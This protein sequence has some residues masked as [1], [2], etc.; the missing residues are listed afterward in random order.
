MQKTINKIAH[1][2]RGVLDFSLIFNSFKTEYEATG[3]PIEV[4][5]RD[6]VKIYSGI[7][8]YT[9]LIH[10]YPAK[11]LLNIPFFFLRCSELI[12]GKSHILDPFCGSG[13]VLLEGIIEGH[14]VHGADANPLARMITRT[15]TNYITTE[16]LYKTFNEISEKAKSKTLKCNYKPQNILDWNYW[17]SPQ[18]QKS[19]SRV[20]SAI[21]ELDQDEI[22]DFFNICFSLCVRK[23]SYA[24]PNISVPV[25][26]NPKRYQG[27]KNKKTQRYLQSIKT[28]NVIEVFGKAVINNIKRIDKLGT[29]KD[30][31]MVENI[32]EDAKELDI[33]KDESIDFIITSPPYSGAQKYIRSSSLSLGWLWLCPGEKLRNLE[34]K[35]IGREHYSKIEY[36]EMPEIQLEDAHQV[37]ERIRQINPLRAH[38]AGNYLLE[39]QSALKECYRVLKSNHRMVIIIGNNMV[40][41]HIF[42][43]RKYLADFCQQIGFF[44][45]LVL[46]DDINSRGLMTK[47]NITA[48]VIACEWILVLR[49]K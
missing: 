16:I 11:L 17:Y 34:K 29:I 13:T 38:I 10:P 18:I 30:L 2:E 1:D 7:D 35:N 39:M 44:L 9:H 21:D 45:E 27:E 22:K 5:F 19:L 47:R 48:S 26:L 24:D 46:R 23:L 15:K 37:L 36:E 8:R 4:N 20:A 49:K 14:H 25:K 6:L 3:V 12:N 43:I 32:F 33:L 28:S 40:C 42:E 31:G 41:N